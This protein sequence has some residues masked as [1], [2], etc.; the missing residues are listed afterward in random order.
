KNPDLLFIGM[1]D[2]DK[3]WHDL[4]SLKISTGELKLIS[5]NKDRLS[6][7]VFDWDDNL[8]LATRSNADGS[9]DILSYQPDGAYKKIYSAAL[10]ETAYPHSFTP[11]NKKVYV[12]SNTGSNRNLTELLLMDPNTGATSFVEKDPDNKV[13]FGNMSI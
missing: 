7:Y 10:F 6:G 8:R 11:D 2:R 13:D 3:S 12:V 1:N 9:T 4:Y 5:E